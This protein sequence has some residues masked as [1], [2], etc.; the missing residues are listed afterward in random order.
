MKKF[1][2][3]SAIVFQCNSLCKASRV[4][5]PD[6]SV[7]FTRP[8]QV[9]TMNF[10]LLLI[11]KTVMMIMVKLEINMKRTIM[12]IMRA[13]VMMSLIIVAITMG[14]MMTLD[15]DNH[16]TMMMMTLVRMTM[17]AMWM[18]M[19]VSVAIP[20]SHSVDSDGSTFW[21][22]ATIPLPLLTNP[23]YHDDDDDDFLLMVMMM[24]F[25]MR[26]DNKEVYKIY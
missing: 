22:L 9:G 5:L 7:W 4:Q 18:T 2:C 8:F 13:V 16:D 6:P 12:L 20:I 1:V 14:F 21:P 26:V 3:K 19:M 15:S 24:L 23:H 17:M 11:I 10:P 25:F